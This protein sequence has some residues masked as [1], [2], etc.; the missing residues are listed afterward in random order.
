[1]CGIYGNINNKKTTEYYKEKLNL[2]EHRGPDNQSFYTDKNLFLGH[3]RLSILDLNSNANQPFEDEQ[4]VL[5]FNGE[6][7]NFIE[8]HQEYLLDIKLKTHSDT[9]ILFLLLKKIGK[10]IIKRLNGMFAFAFYDKTNKMVLIARDTMGIKPLYYH[11]TNDSMEFASEIKPLNFQVDFNNVKQFVIQRTYQNGYLPYSNIDEF[12]IG[13][14]AIYDI[15]T[16][17][18]EINK[19]NKIDEIPS[20]EIYLR[21]TTIK[22]NQQID[23]LDELMKQSI[24]L[25]LQSD[26]KIGSLCS[27]GVDSSLISAIAT[28]INPNVSLYHAGVDG[29]GGEEEYAEMVSKHINKEINYIKVSAET[30]WKVFPYLTYISDLPIYHPND[31]SL[32][33]IAEKAK[34]DGIKVLLSGEGADELFG[35]YSWHKNLIQRKKLFNLYDKYPLFGKIAK[36]LLFKYTKNG[37]NSINNKNYKN[38][39]PLGLGYSDLNIENLSK[40]ATFMSNDFKNWKDWQK[41]LKIYQDFDANEDSNFA[42]S[43]MFNNLYGH[44][45][46]ILHRTDR[47]LMANS[48]E[49]RVPFLE[50]EIINFALNLPYNNKINNQEGKFLLKKV[51]ERYL[52]HEVIYRTK[53]GF[54]VPWVN[55]IGKIEKIFENGFILDLLDMS[56]DDLKAYYENDV[57]AKFSLISL[58]VWGRIFVRQE[59]YKSIIVE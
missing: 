5:I 41:H 40:S 9:E 7:Y 24:E 44:L 29:V 6:I 15:N 34:F 51:S 21:N 11:L 45:G 25:H 10:D 13:H 50:N 39:M 58:E 49:G 22:L 14:Y 56:L 12:P 32:H 37:L 47:I 59:D 4:N 43:L 53:A 55:Y 27:G 46:S 38:F 48:I 16:L 17:K 54:P 19:Y 36:R 30:Y 3:T 26:A 28:K 57:Y 35:G 20:K 18:F 1:M 52:P 42:L 23:K 2:L 8:L 31:V 33:Y